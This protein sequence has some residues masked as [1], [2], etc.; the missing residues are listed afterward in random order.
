MIVATT[1]RLHLRHWTI[2]DA[3]S[4]DAIYGDAETMRMFGD[5][6]TFTRAAIAESLSDIVREYAVR[7]YANYAVIERATD[8]VIGHCG[9][10]ATGRDFAEADWVI[11]REWQGRGYA[12]EAARA[13]FL[14]AFLVDRVEE[15]RGVAHVDNLPSIRVLEK[16]GMRRGGELVKH[17]MPSVEYTL[18]RDDFVLPPARDHGI[19]IF[20]AV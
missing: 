17:G 7:G 11:G 20:P 5:G 18:R 19:T 13:V 12:T 6:S 10:H 2:E 15:I 4:T 16:L 9:A 14:R 1:P 3:P 8:R